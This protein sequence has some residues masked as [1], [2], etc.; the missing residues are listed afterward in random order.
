[1]VNVT[2]ELTAPEANRITVPE[3]ESDL[4]DLMAEAVKLDREIKANEATKKRR[5]SAVTAV[6]DA[7]NTPLQARLDRLTPVILAYVKANRDALTDDGKKQS[8]ETVDTIVKF[9]KDTKGT[10]EMEDEDAVVAL[11]EEL[12]EGEAFV[13]VKKSVRKDPFKKWLAEKA[14]RDVEGVVIR[15]KPSLTIQL[16]LTAAEKRRGV[17]PHVLTRDIVE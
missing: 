12:P 15:F 16:K 13:E 17:K 3:S 8:F 2:T 7:R 14:G 9:R 4:N 10:L 1:M 6:I 11:L 5:I